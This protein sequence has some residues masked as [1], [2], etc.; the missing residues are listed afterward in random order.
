MWSVLCILTLSVF[1]I[2]R[3]EKKNQ[4]NNYRFSPHKKKKKLNLKLIVIID[5]VQYHLDKVRGQEL[6]S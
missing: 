2:M 1:K 4:N 6:R 3:N 5:A